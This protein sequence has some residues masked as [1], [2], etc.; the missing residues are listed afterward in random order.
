MS[1][2]MMVNLHNEVNILYK[3]LAA[4]ANIVN[5]QDMH[6]S[7]KNTSVTIPRVMPNTSLGYTN[8]FYVQHDDGYMK[9]YNVTWDGP[10]TAIGPR[11]ED[12]T[13]LTERPL[14]GSHFS[15]TALP[16]PSGGD[17]LVVLNQ[18]T[19]DDITYNTRDFGAGTWTDTEIPVPDA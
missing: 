4:T 14:A 8:L 6:E 19:G 16:N 1:Y 2:L 11:K 10:N 9:G 3:D 17:D 15:V 12:V 13:L 18:Q 5:L 7:W